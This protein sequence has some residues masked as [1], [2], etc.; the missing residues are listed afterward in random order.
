[1]T[2]K[3]KSEPVAVQNLRKIHYSGQ[4]NPTARSSKEKT[5]IIEGSTT[6]TVNG[7]K[8]D[9]IKVTL[10]NKSTT[11]IKTFHT[12]KYKGEEKI[13]YYTRQLYNH[14]RVVNKE[15]TMRDAK[16]KK[17]YKPPVSLVK[18]NLKEEKRFQKTEL[19]NKKRTKDERLTYSRATYQTFLRIGIVVKDGNR[20]PWSY[21]SH[22]KGLG[23]LVG[24]AGYHSEDYMLRYVLG[25]EYSEF[26]H[27]Y[28][29]WRRHKRYSI[30]YGWTYRVIKRPT[31]ISNGQLVIERE[32]YF[33]GKYM[34]K[35]DRLKQGRHKGGDIKV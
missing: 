12:K 13:A 17:N 10:P 11:T 26:M 25:R 1:M 8:Y 14:R 2:P 27:Y 16:A 18:Q 24:K 35:T 32:T 33:S 22:G 20:T 30:Y 34:T 9:Y 4:A 5:A 28:N 15:L 7:V 29:L 21:P 19:Y 6:R 31:R 23:G 3:P